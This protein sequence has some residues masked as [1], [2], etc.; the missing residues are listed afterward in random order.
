MPHEQET[1]MRAEP[2]TGSVPQLPPVVQLPRQSLGLDEGNKIPAR[3]QQI[4][5]PEQQLVDRGV[6]ARRAD[7]VEVRYPE[8][9]LAL[10]G[11]GITIC[12]PWHDLGMVVPKVGGGHTERLED[13]ILRVAPQRTA[14]HALHNA[15]EQRIAGVAI[16]EV[17]PRRKVQLFLPTDEVEDI[18]LGFFVHVPP[19]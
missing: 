6:Q 13:A 3:R 15:G 16:G 12:A 1:A 5:G 2:H 7:H 17:L 11:V 19:P 10:A 14:A 8:P 4:P 9:E 18:I